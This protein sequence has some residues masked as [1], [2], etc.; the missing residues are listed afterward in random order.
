MKL[1]DR[2]LVLLAVTASASLSHAQSTKVRLDPSS[3]PQPAFRQS[4]LELARRSHDPLDAT[5]LAKFKAL[6]LQHGWPTVVAVERDG[7]DAAGDLLLRSRAD[8]DFQNDCL[9]QAFHQAYIDT[10]ARAV[11]A[12]NDRI[13]MA[14]GHPQQGGM[15]F[16]LANGKVALSPPTDPINA[17]NGLR[18]NYSLPTV[19]ADIRRLQT[20]MD[21]GASLKE[22]AAPPRLSTKTYPIHLP[23]LSTE[24][25]AM[26]SKD[27]DVRNAFIQSGMKM[28]SPEQRAVIETDAA[29]LARLR[30][31][32]QKY[33][34][35]SRA[36]VGRGGV[37]NAWLLVQH[38]STD[39]AFMAKA[40]ER[41]RPLMLSGDLPR[42]NYALLVDRVRLQQGKKQLYGSQLKG[43]PGHFETLPLDDPEH[44]DQRRSEMGM[45]PLADYI[46]DTNT[47][48]TP[49]PAA[50]ASN[51]ASNSSASPSSH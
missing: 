47:V 39:P 3:S 25:A 28:N 50:A 9:A 15:L 8:Y 38:A 17:I 26:A 21:R 43:E 35:P 30:V 45:E 16:T 4:L 19:A 1:P 32:F 29:D 22:I 51:P 49:K 44:V 24:L 10:D 36:L 6:I 18:G 7:V 48:Y 41:A 27:A 42:P 40:L 2:L 5:T 13:E 23:A 12:L 20:A 33:G 31:I 14:Q 37:N 34:F 46:R 11:L